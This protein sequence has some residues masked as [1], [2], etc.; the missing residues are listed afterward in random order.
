MLEVLRKMKEKQS[1]S[2]RHKIPPKSSNNEFKPKWMTLAMEEIARLRK[3]IIETRVSK[4]NSQNS[5]RVTRSR[6][7]KRKRFDDQEQHKEIKGREYPCL[8]SGKKAGNGRVF[9]A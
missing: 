9:G 7:A 1:G 6:V 3:N 4:S 8:V 2:F 5:S